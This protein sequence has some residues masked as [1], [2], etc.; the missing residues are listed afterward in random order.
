M[1]SPPNSKISPEMSNV[2]TDF[3]FPIADN[4]FLI[5][6]ILMVKGLANSID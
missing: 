4:R 2:P 5:M 6:L 1:A 3:F